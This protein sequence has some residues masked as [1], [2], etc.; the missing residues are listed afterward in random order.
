VA[1][2]ERNNGKNA[3][4]RMNFRLLWCAS[5]DERKKYIYF[6]LINLNLLSYEK[7]NL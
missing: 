3:F 2:R 6:Y 4:R 5:F 1:P 7:E